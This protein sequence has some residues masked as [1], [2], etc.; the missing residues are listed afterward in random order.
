MDNH[1]NESRSIGNKRNGTKTKT[2]K[3]SD[4]SFEIA[5]PQDR[6]S[7]FEPQIVK[8]RETI[9]ENNRLI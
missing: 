5:T 4:G 2:L 9:V 6:Q 1:I 8:K 3:S 7:S